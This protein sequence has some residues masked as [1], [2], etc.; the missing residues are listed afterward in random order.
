MLDQRHMTHCGSASVTVKTGLVPFNCFLV[1]KK[2]EIS[3]MV[4]EETTDQ[5]NL[6]MCV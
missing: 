4:R 6:Q 3:I 2:T 1:L 5:V